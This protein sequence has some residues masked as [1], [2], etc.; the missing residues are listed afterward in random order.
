LKKA[1]TATALSAALLT[2]GACTATSLYK[3]VQLNV[4]GQVL[5]ASG[6]ALTVADVLATKGIVLGDRDVVSP[7]KDA[8]VPTGGT[9]TVRFSK[10]VTLDVDGTPRTFLTNA[11]TLDEALIS[12]ALS[13]EPAGLVAAADGSGLTGA[14]MSVPLAT[15]LPRAGLTVQVTTPKKV[16]LKLAGT[17]TELTT[18]A[19]TVA[20][21]LTEQGIAL[22]AADRLAPLGTTPVV[23]G[24]KIVLDRVTVKS[25]TKTEKV[26]FATT[27]R[28]NS[29]LWK[30]ESRVVTAGRSGKAKR[31]YLITVVN[32]KVEKKV[33]LTETVVAKATAQVLEVGTKTSANGVGINLARA[34]MWDRIARCE[35]GGNWHINTGNGYYGGLQFNLA[36]WRSNGGRDFAARPDQASRAEQI[37]VANRY[38]AKAGTRPWTCA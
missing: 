35:S 25:R 4:D 22:G 37:T 36:S 28:K 16:V 8:P 17:P 5:P 1:I 14:R 6:F 31:T 10:P 23:E 11:A 3:S 21:L 32:G 26:A 12:D 24:Q 20:D 13:A 9:V 15:P 19:P 29:S 30:G 34:G 2:G 33:V 18:N 7:A 38:Y 27:T